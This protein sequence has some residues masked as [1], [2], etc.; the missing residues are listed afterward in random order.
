MLSITKSEQQILCVLGLVLLLGSVGHVVFAKY[1]QIK[2][3]ANFIDS[4]VIIPKADINTALKEQLMAIPYI[5]EFTAEKIIQHREFS[6]LEEIKTIPGIRQKNFDRF[7]K[8]L[9]VSK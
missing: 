7:V 2:N 5:G 1:P 9:K 6:S 8:Y 3:I 4:D